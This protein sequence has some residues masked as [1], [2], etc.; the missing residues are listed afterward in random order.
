MLYKKARRWAVYLANKNLFIHEKKDPGNL[1]LSAGKPKEPCTMAVQ[2][3]YTEEKNY[4]Y[5][6]PEDFKGAGHFT[7]VGFKVFLYL[8]TW[9][10]SFRYE[11]SKQLPQSCSKAYLLLSRK[12][13]VE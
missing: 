1:F 12:M 2:L 10:C 9:C 5:N 11:I 4:D 8:F 7:Q 3:F 6:D 13:V